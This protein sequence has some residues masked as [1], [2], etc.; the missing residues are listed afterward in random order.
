MKR[1]K[2]FAILLAALLLT[3]G[4]GGGSALKGESAATSSASAMAPEA[5]M[6]KV[7]FDSAGGYYQESG[8]G[9]AVYQRADA[10]L[11]RRCTM[12]MQTEEY[13]AAI[14]ELY[15]LVSRLEGYFESSTQRGGSY[16]NADAQ[17]WGE[18][19]IR[20]PAERY[21][22]FRSGA[23]ELGYITYCTESTEDVGEQYYDTEARLKTLRTKQ[24]RLLMLLE[25]AETMEDIITLESA[26]SEVEYEIEQHS[27]TLNRYD[28]L[29]SYATFY[30]NVHE[31][32][33][34][35]D[36][37]GE[38]DSLWARMTKGFSSGFNSFVDGVQDLMVWFSYNLFGLLSLGVLILGGVFVIRKKGMKGFGKKRKKGSD[39]VEP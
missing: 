23:G 4:C 27:S 15:A 35:E 39:S 7:E 30:F 19:V 5:P 21:D 32:L 28:G 11:I 14:Q 8:T 18:Y 12:E 22:E 26:L 13:D 10:K 24:D 2:F 33:R 29:I 37:V 25:K 17:R 20:I 34:V 1:N 38:A 16:Y 36:K 31:V 9:S 3:S 6:E